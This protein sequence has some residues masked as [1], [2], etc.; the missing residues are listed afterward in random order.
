MAKQRRSNR[1]VHRGRR[2]KRGF[3]TWSLGKK[4]GVIFVSMLLVIVIGGGA[5][6][7]AYVTSKMDKM[8]V[9]QLDANK[10]EINQEVE[11][12]TGYLNVALFG[13]DSRELSLGKGTRSD[14]IIVASLNQ[15]TGEIKL[16][17]VYR[18]SLL[19]QSDGS[20]NKANAAYSFGGV[21]GAVALLNK[22]LDMNI[23]HYVTVNFNALSDVVDALGGL[24]IE[25]THTEA[26]LTNGYFEEVAKV[27]GR[28]F[29]MVDGYEGLIHVN[30]GQATAF[31]RIR[32]TQGDD[33]KRT[34]RQRL[35]IEKIVEKLQSANLATINKIIDISS[36]QI[37]TSRVFDFILI[38][39]NKISNKIYFDIIRSLRDIFYNRTDFFSAYNYSVLLHK[40]TN[41]NDNIMI[42]DMYKE[43]D[44]LNHCGSIRKSK[45]L[46]QQVS[47]LAL[48]MNEVRI[49]IEA[50][51]EVYNIRFWLLDVND[52]EVEIDKTLDKYFINKK[53]KSMKGRELYPYYNCLNRKM[54]TQYLLNKYED[55]EITFKEILNK[56]KLNNYIA[57]AYMDSARGLYNKDISTAYERIKKAT[58]YL[59]NLFQ[60]GDEI[61]RYYDCLIEK[62]YIEFIIANNENRKI[63]IKQLKNT[64][65]DATKYGFKNIVEKS[66][67][68]L[69]ACYL[70]LSDLEKSKE[71]LDKIKNNPYFDNSPRNQIMY[72][73]LM[74]GYFHLLNVRLGNALNIS[75]DFC[76]FSNCINFKCFDNKVDNCFYIDGRMW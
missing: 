8:E 37:W 53:T 20:Y 2:K 27:T 50:L 55:A 70:V 24:D 60:K 14:T 61:R 62:A 59:E 22:N 38:C 26:E 29:E 33:F 18:D 39:E 54:V 44:E 74:E 57:F 5:A 75:S 48:E 52:L 9:E 47:N 23:E 76:E 10:L 25:M 12:K 32:Y 30:G 13:V 72:N 65:Y 66:Y 58:E 46:F 17:S 63:E 15:E 71:Y 43:A 64:I 16:C 35:V 1:K 3:S 51:T 4:I 31:C 21:E 11:H 67:F 41:V 68:K 6:A 36:K 28:E 49:G 40:D 34:E 19:Q 42:D 73:D 7:A 69:A 56:T 45:E